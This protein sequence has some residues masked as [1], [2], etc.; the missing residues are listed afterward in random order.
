MTLEEINKL[1][2]ECNLEH[3]KELKRLCSIKDGIITENNYKDKKSL[4]I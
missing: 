2:D 1:I 4:E 3:Y